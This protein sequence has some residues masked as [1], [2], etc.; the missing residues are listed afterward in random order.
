MKSAAAPV[1]VS[2][3]ELTALVL[4]IEGLLPQG[5]YRLIKAVVET[6]MHMM[7][8]LDNQRMTIRRLCQWLFGASSE[9]TRHVL[10]SKS[11]GNA[12]GAP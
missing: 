3:E 8:L 9:K 10:K 2:R 1:N 12:A 6:L 5:D 7:W 11:G 4:R